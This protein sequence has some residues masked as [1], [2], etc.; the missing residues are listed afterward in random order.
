M[1]NLNLKYLIIFIASFLSIKLPFIFT[2][3]LMAE[4]LNKYDFNIVKSKLYLKDLKHIKKDISQNINSEFR[5]YLKED[6]LKLGNDLIYLIAFEEGVSKNNFTLDIESDTQYEKENIFYAEGNAVLYFS[7]AVLKANIITYEKD[8]KTLIA[9][10]NVVFTKGSQYFEASKVSY[11][12]NNRKGFID[13]IYGVLNFNDFIHDFEFKNIKEKNDINIEKVSDL[14]YIDSVKI[15]LVNDFQPTKKFNF[16]NVSFDI[17]SITIWRYKSKKI[18]FNRNILDSEKILFTNDTFN[19]PQ[20]ILESNNFT[21]EI[22]DNKIKLISRDSKLIFDDK[23]KIPIGKRTIYDDESSSSWGFGSDTKEKDGFYIYNNLRK[24]KFNDFDVKFRP[25]FLIQR[26]AEGESKVFRKKNSSM[27]SK[28]V[29]NDIRYSDFFALDSELDGNINSFNLNWKSS[30]NSFNFSRFHEAV[31]S[32]LTIKKTLDLSSSK[33]NFES[34]SNI[35]IQKFSD[36]PANNIFDIVIDN[37]LNNTKKN[38]DKIDY[39]NLFDIKF[40]SAYREKV[41]KGYQGDSE[42][43]FG[44]ALSLANRKYWKKKGNSTNLF[45][46]YDL[47]FF[48]ARRKS[49]QEFADLNR[50]VFALKLQNKYQLWEK[51]KAQKNINQDYKYTP[52]LI[53]EGI[54]WHTNI[55]SGLFVYSDGSSQKAISLGTGPQVTIGK[56]KNK[57]LDYTKINLNGI[58]VLKEGESP[59]DFDDINKNF[60]LNIKVSQQ[61]FGPLVFSY[62]TSYDFDDEIYSLPKYRIDMKRRAYSIGTFYNKS[63]ESIGFNLNIF[64]FNYKGFPK[65]F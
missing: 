43:Y 3:S 52:S 45:L 57:F 13:N 56:L 30:L 37:D 62:E 22:I 17:P 58:Y 54:S 32:K 51:N 24:L 59:F 1:I 60:R 46:I 49:I 42:I 31:R 23:L 48:K 6:I 28:R 2:I 40:T 7:N 61:I 11:D 19:K 29:I 27:L 4:E 18:N 47:G 16:S 12:F 35:P 39:S 5:N 26:T 25:Y 15:G 20:F 21:G 44:N 65:K 41:S 34:K 38:S 63:N 9:K 14:K 55:Q 36:M 10:G 8:S 64:N 50:N 33:N 53:N